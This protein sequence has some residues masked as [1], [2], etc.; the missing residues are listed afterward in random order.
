MGGLGLLRRARLAGLRVWSRDGRVV[1]EGREDQE[2]LALELLARKAEVLAELAR[3]Q[4]GPWPKETCPL[5]ADVFE[6]RSLNDLERLGSEGR[7]PGACYVCGGAAW[8]RLKSGT[9]PC[10]G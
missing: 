10:A 2:L 7:A 9:E 6:I 8:W 4:A 5:T 3:E 1:V